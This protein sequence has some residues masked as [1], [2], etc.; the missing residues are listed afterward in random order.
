MK[1]LHNIIALKILSFENKIFK[2]T[3]NRFI[4]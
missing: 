4:S 3:K 2:M 1:K